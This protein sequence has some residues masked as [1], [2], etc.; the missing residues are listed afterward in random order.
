MAETTSK[1]S[2]DSAE[3]HVP[4]KE[5][6]EF[7]KLLAIN[8]NYFG[9]LEKSLYKVV[10]QMVGNTTYEEVTCVGFNQA[11][12]LL[13]A[14]I[15]IKR[16]GGYNGT[17]CTLGSTEYVRFF[18]D[19]GGGW[20]DVGLASFNAHDIP[21]IVDCAKDPDKPLSFVVT[22][23]LSPERNICARPVLPNVRAIL[24]WQLVP[25]A[26]NTNANW[27]PIW[28]NVHDQHVQIKPRRLWFG[29]V[30]ELLPKEALKNLPPLVEEAKPIPIP[31]PDPPSLSLGHLAQLYK[32]T[33]KTAAAATVEP[34][35]FG[36]ADLEAL[37]TSG[38]QEMLIA[39]NAEWKSA[40][41]D[42]AV[43]LA[44]LDQTNADISYEELECL[45]LEY[46]LDRLVA[47]F[48]IKRPTGYSGA[49][50]T[51][52]S[53]EYVAFWADWNDTCQ[54][55]YL[56]TLA[57]NVHDISTIPPDG[58]AY[59][60]ILPVDLSAIRRPCGGPGG[61]PK[62]ARIRAVLSWNTP[63]STTNPDALNHWGNR[64]DAHVQIRPGVQVP[65]DQPTISIIGGVGV[66]DINV[67]GD[68]MTKP[69]ATFA[70]GGS[71]ADPWLLNRECPFGGLIVLQGPPVLGFKY[72]LWARKFGNPATEEIV[73]NAFH[74]VNWLGV[75]S[76]ITPD[77]LTGYA[78]YISTLSNIDQ[79][80]AH[81][82][83]AGDELWEIRLEMATLGGVV[84]GT[85]A[86]HSV[87]L[88][89][90]APR[91]RPAVPPFEPPAVT[92]EIHID[93][94]GDCKDFT[95]ST[96]VHGHFVARDDNMGG[97]S[98]MTLPT[99]MAPN[100]PTTGTP[101]TSNT[102]TFVAGGDA[103]QLDTTGMQPCGYV[104]LL[105]VWDRSIL[106]SQPGSHNYNFYDV[107]FC[108]K[109]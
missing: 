64:M 32:A 108:L 65:G 3:A 48:R 85:T 55:T 69:T 34:H 83:P 46:N 73:K 11:L 90:T 72:R 76:N 78:A 26:G 36:L 62:I 107:G 27:S 57:V 16:P 47:T 17:L 80:L 30:L 2:I 43:A 4:P 41:I 88:D 33:G 28:G 74:I 5:R 39:A 104:V 9:N 10:K 95:A 51:P 19:Y 100:S 97:F 18:V 106:G 75:G 29:D 56:T 45:G 82:T 54:W 13:E 12:D 79:V 35:R 38:N 8:P 1:R 23:P 93:S 94:G 53:Q 42:L 22:L 70:L 37:V 59:S 87:Q 61:G 20:I 99:S 102:A 86:W 63:P 6:L 66:A 67:F 15:H 7:K 14:T 50:C 92:C 101:A 24:S 109:E 31:L 89:N 91:R 25:P 21:N 103:W 58:L 96:L 44:G 60:A 98:L 49:L 68:G 81:W 105:Q 52:G 77:P 84:V 71:P 40:G